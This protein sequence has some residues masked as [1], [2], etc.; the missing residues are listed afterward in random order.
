MNSKI[1]ND[2][3]SEINDR[4]EILTLVDL[5]VLR[6]ECLTNEND[7]KKSNETKT[8]YPTVAEVDQNLIEYLYYLFTKFV[9]DDPNESTMPIIDKKNFVTVCQTLVR[10]GCFDMPSSTSPDQSASETISNNSDPTIIPDT[11]LHEYRN[12][13]VELS[14][15]KI[16][17]NEQETWLVVDL[18]PTQSEEH[19]TTSE[20]IVS[21]FF[22]FQ[23]DVLQNLK[24]FFFVLI[25]SLMTLVFIVIRRLFSL[26]L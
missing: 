3:L 19:A 17:N 23:K 16:T 8:N 15:E 12:S 1:S 18:Q 10:N 20:I 22:Y 13:K 7:L 5:L 26:P 6:V 14:S 2:N 25:I 9:H 4:N 11:Y 21:F 24:S